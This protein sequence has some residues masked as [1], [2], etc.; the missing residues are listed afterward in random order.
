MTAPPLLEA[1]NIS[2]TRD[3]RTILDTVS[4]SIGR[5]EIVTLIG[6]NGAGKTSLVKLCLG[7]VKPT[8]G[9]VTRAPGLKIGY[10]PQRL[11]V[12]VTLP[13]PVSRFLSL[14]SRARRADMQVVLAEVGAAH[15]IDRAIQTLSGGELQ[16]VLLARALLRQPD[17][18]V[19]DEPV[20]A[21]D[22]HGQIELFELIGSIRNR[23]GCGVLLVSHDLHLV[24]ARTDTVICLNR[25]VCCHGK[26]EDVSRHPEYVALFGRH[27]DAL[28]IY[29]HSHDHSHADDGCVVPA[30]HEHTAHSEHQGCGHDHHHLHGHDQAHGGHR[31]G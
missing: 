3:G 17:L 31:H 7:L 10:M 15:A 23:R 21:V 5:G 25:H 26:P 1:R 30:G 11:A 22:V 28:A 18:L 9:T 19:L 6:P 12:D 20:Q 14:W 13:M 4:L 29:H 24:M 2:L 27:A 16:R 8:D